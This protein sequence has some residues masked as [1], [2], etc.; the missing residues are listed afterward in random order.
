VARRDG[1][2]IQ[3]LLD[4]HLRVGSRGEGIL[5]EIPAYLRL[6]E[7]KQLLSLISV[8]MAVE[9]EQILAC[10]SLE[11]CCFAVIAML[12]VVTTSKTH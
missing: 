9:F 6:S 11:P 12:C 1:T 8:P 7:G 3:P 5:L 10:C 4:P 2:R